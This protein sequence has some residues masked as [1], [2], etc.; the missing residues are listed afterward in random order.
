MWLWLGLWADKIEER[1]KE[2][3]NEVFMGKKKPQVSKLEKSFRK[4]Y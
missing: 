3:K 1:S 2:G 4:A